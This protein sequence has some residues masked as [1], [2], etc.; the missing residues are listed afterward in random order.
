[1]AHVMGRVLELRVQL[2]D[3]IIVKQKGTMGGEG[4]KGRSHVYIFKMYTYSIYINTFFKRLRYG[5]L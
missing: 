2:K 3:Y 5:N 4:E 1:M